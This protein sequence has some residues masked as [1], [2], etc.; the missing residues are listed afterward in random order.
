MYVTIYFNSFFAYDICASNKA[1]IKKRRE[2]IEINGLIGYIFPCY[3]YQWTIEDLVIVW[4]YYTFS[5]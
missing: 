1:G 3:F 4:L 5:I 2:G